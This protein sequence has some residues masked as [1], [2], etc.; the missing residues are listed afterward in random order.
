MAIKLIGTTVGR[1]DET[2]QPNFLVTVSITPE[3]NID[4]RIAAGLT[5]EQLV[6]IREH[7]RL[8]FDNHLAMYD[9][10]KH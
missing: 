5:R 3:N 10:Q 8:A 6:E 4:T 9:E 2:W 1:A 7:I